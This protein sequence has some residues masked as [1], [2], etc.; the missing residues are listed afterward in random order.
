MDTE[1]VLLKQTVPVQI[2]RDNPDLNGAVD[3][4]VGLD[5]SSAEP[6]T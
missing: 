1:R 3:T 2:E 5:R 6:A 4:L